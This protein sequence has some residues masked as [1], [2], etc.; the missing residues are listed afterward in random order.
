VLLYTPGWI[1]ASPSNP[2]DPRSFSAFVSAFARRYRARLDVYE[3]WNEPDLS[4]YWTGGAQDYVRDV[5]LPGSRAVKANDPGARIV[6][7]G[8]GSAN[9]SWFNE[10]YRFGGGRSFDVLEYHD[11]SAD[12]RILSDAYLLRG[13]LRA[14]R[15]AR[16]PIWLGEYG[17][18]E[19][20]TGDP[21][22]QA[23]IRVGLTGKAPIALAGWYA[24]RDDRVM[25]CCPPATIKEESFGLLTDSYEPKQA[26]A[27]M[28]TLLRSR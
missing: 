6:L 27:T 18:Q 11:Y 22:Q 3:L 4:R 5:L 19:A 28:R 21:R 8:T 17:L 16:K 9:A 15:Q 10:I 2:P 7:G 1:A 12:R 26:Y 14:H 20:G 23:L 24:L 13:V 25:N